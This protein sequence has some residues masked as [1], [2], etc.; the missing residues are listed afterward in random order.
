MCMCICGYVTMSAPE[1]AVQYSVAAST[2]V[3]WELGGTSS[4]VA[5]SVFLKC[6]P[7]G[8]RVNTPHHQRGDEGGFKTKAPIRHSY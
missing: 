1:L 6:L 3:L 4:D 2:N 8:S 5:S 7:V